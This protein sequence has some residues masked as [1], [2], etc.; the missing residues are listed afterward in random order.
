[1]FRSPPRLEGYSLPLGRGAPNIV[2]GFCS[3]FF[4]WAASVTGELFIYG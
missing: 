2:L 1:V 3:C 4:I